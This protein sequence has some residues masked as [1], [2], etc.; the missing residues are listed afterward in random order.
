MSALDP[1]SSPDGKP[2]K[3]L[4]G[5]KFINKYP[6]YILFAIGSMLL[7]IMLWAAGNKGVQSDGQSSEELPKFGSTQ[8]MAEK[9]TS[10]YHDGLI[11]SNEPPPAPADPSNEQSDNNDNPPPPSDPIS[12]LLLSQNN[13]NPSAYSGFP[14]QNSYRTEEDTEAER[15]R[16]MKMQRFQEAVHARTAIAVEIRSQNDSDFSSGLSSTSVA[17]QSREAMLARL[18][19][20]RSQ[21][22]RQRQTDPT[23]AY[24]QRMAALKASGLMP[25]TG[26]SAG[27]DGGASLLPASTAMDSDNDYSVFD[28][29]GQ[30]DRWQS[31]ERPQAPR[32]AFELRAGFIIPATM[33]SGINSDLPGQLMAQVSQNVFD[34]ATGRHLLVP[35]GTRLVGSYSSDVIYGQSRILIAWQRLVF[36]DGRALDLG[37]MPGADNAG[38]SGFND[39]VNNHYLRL[40]GNALLMSGITAGVSLSQDQ[41]INESQKSANNDWLKMVNEQQNSLKRDAAKL[42]QLQANAQTA[43]GQMEALSYANQFASQQNHLLMQMHTTLLAQQQAL[44]IQQSR[45]KDLEDRNKVIT[46]QMMNGTF[47]RPLRKSY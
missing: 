16:T 3:D 17:P 29:T 41:L 37:S 5:G 14:N 22:E 24:Q 26:I 38:Y 25:D 32:S 21:L 45:Q 23:A 7:L 40:F 36:P 12:A 47:N 8:S 44:A 18:A 2:K 31:K 4:F 19:A 1:E 9:L 46:E 11:D 28:K 13:A 43:T 27:M 15:I 35:Q 33:I 39:K 10:S 6:I 30:D 20:V 34:T 42:S